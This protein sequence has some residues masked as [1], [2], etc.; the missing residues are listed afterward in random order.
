MRF[1]FIPA[2]GRVRFKHAAYLISHPAK[3][4]QFF[5]VRPGSMGGIIETPVMPVYLPR[6][7]GAGLV[8]IAADGDD[9][10]H[11][12]MQKL[13]HVPGAMSGNIYAYLGHC[14]DSQRMDV[15]GRV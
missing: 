15:T 13:V 7:H 14:P 11:F 12:L 6:K 2:S 8:G 9:G 10:F 4:L 1:R 5:F 3:Y